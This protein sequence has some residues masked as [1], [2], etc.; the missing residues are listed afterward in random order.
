MVVHKAFGEM[1]NRDPV[2]TAP[3]PFPVANAP[4]AVDSLLVSIGLLGLLF[5][6][7]EGKGQLVTLACIVASVSIPVGAKSREAYSATIASAGF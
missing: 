5:L 3:V 7:S 4:P 2:K 1:D 6:L